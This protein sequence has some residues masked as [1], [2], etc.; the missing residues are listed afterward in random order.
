MEYNPGIAPIPVR[1]RAY[2]P[3][4][5][6]YLLSLRVTPHNFCFPLWLTDRLSVDMKQTMHSLN[7]MGLAL[8]DEKYQMIPGHDVVIDID[9]QLEA[10]RESFMGEPAFVDYR[11]FTLNDELYLHVNSDTVILTKL[12]LRSEGIGNPNDD[13]EDSILKKMGHKQIKLKNLYGGDQ[14]KVTLL[15]QFNTIWGEGKKSGYGKNYA[16]FSLPNATHPTAPDSVYAEMSVHPDHLVQ[17][18]LPDEYDKL[19]RGRI[20]LRQRRNFKVD[21]IMQRKMRKVGNATQ[22]STSDARSARVPSFFTADE[23]WFPGSKNPF[24]EFAHGGA[25]CVSLSLEE[26]S[27]AGVVVPDAKKDGNW[28]GIDSVLVG[29]GHTLVMFYA[30]NKMPSNERMLIPDTNYVSFLYAFDPRPPFQLLARSGYFCLGFASTSEDEEGGTINP[31]SV[32]THNRPLQ[33]NNETFACAQIHYVSTIIEKLGDSSTAVIGYGMNDC[34]ARLVEVSKKEIA[35][36]LFPDPWDMV[37][38]KKPS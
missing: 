36:L 29:V 23:H 28:E 19:P 34:T 12:R 25:C 10:K 3:W 4:N 16:L 35:R 18:I 31:H 37:A 20:K 21:S 17:Q 6:R 5:A 27:E 14:F 13:M 15:H 32:L 2:L 7:H 9:R 33:Q 1:I 38:S 30:K 24:K 11:L 8:L 22:S 26:M